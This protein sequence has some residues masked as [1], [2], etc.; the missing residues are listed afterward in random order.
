MKSLNESIIQVVT[1][2]GSDL[3]GN[4]KPQPTII[5]GGPH[6]LKQQITEDLESSVNSALEQIAKGKSYDEWVKTTKLSPEVKAEVKR[7]LDAQGGDQKEESPRHDKQHLTKAVFDS[8]PDDEKEQHQDN[9]RSSMKSHGMHDDEEQEESSPEEEP[10]E[11][12]DEEDPDGEY[13]GDYDSSPEP[14][15]GHEEED[16]KKEPEMKLSKKKEKVTINPKMEEKSFNKKLISELKQKRLGRIDEKAVSKQQQKYFGLVRAIQKGEA[17]GSPEAEKTAKEMSMKDVKDYASTKHKGLPRKVQSENII[18]MKNKEGHT[19]VI[20]D[21]D[22]KGKSQDKV[23]MHVQDKDGKKIKDYGSHV[24]ADR[25]K[26]FAKA[27]GFSEDLRSN[28]DAI[29]KNEKKE[30]K[31]DEM[32]GDMAYR[33]MDKAHKK[34]RGEMSVNDPE[35]AKKKARQA[36]KFADYSIKK[37]LNKEEVELEENDKAM[38]MKLTTKAMKAI[39][40]SPKQKELIKQVNVY[41]EKL[42]MKPMRED[43]SELDESA[44]LQMKMAADDIET[45]A[46]K[47]GGIDKKDMMKTASMLKKGNKKGALKFIKTL[48]TDPR[49]YL[50]KTMGEELNNEDKPTIKKIIKS[51]KKSSQSH[52]GQADKLEKSMNEK[53]D[54]MTNADQSTLTPLEVIKALKD[55]VDSKDPSQMEGQSFADFEKERLDQMMRNVQPGRSVLMYRIRDFD[56]GDA[57]EIENFTYVMKEKIPKYEQMGYKVVAQ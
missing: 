8:L 9:L 54:E 34:S 7:R 41:R 28:I 23:R 51:L 29:K 4:A 55:R 49:D 32:S 2:G 42:G 25:A 20:S 38:M 16:E 22:V 27:R 37:T 48:D 36:Q 57:G 31:M 17:S 45:Y 11:M 47:H 21:R 5:Q 14:D 39:P 35:R 26:R 19:F 40:N 6:W 46:K 3:S 18:E 56:T 1:V 24:S 15:E 10:E 44:L 30:K 12:E 50:L 43:Y 33:A 53:Y 13:D 52:S